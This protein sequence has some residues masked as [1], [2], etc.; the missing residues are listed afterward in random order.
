MNIWKEKKNIAHDLLEPYG[1]GKNFGLIQ[2]HI[3]LIQF[4]CY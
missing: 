4:F 1:W 3:K 2:G